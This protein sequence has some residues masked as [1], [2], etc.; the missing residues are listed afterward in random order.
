MFLLIFR[1]P[2]YNEQMGR[3]RTE[4]ELTRLR[5]A[6]SE[7]RY[8]EGGGKLKGPQQRPLLHFARSRFLPVGQSVHM[9]TNWKSQMTILTQSL[10]KRHKSTS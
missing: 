3:V 2:P 7:A 1:V 6:A 5:G 4:R 10:L 8:R 9:S